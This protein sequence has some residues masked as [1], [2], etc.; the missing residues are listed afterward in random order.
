MTVI[1]NHIFS[2]LYRDNLSITAP[3]LDISFVSTYLEQK[4][5]L[6]K[7]HCAYDLINLIW[8]N[9]TFENSVYENGQNTFKQGRTDEDLYKFYNGCHFTQLFGV[10]VERQTICSKSHDANQL[11]VSLGIKLRAP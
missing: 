7:H 11:F 10:I 9:L 5:K 8:N 6:Q 1:M 4:S 2:G 3:Y